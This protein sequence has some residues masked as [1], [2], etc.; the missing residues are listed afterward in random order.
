MKFPRIMACLT[1]GSC[2]FGAGAAFGDQID[3]AMRLLRSVL[4]ANNTVQGEGCNVY[5]IDLGSS[6]EAI[7]RGGTDADGGDRA[8][9]NVGHSAEQAAVTVQESGRSFTLTESTVFR[10]RGGGQEESIFSYDDGTRTI[11]IRNGKSRP[12]IC[13]LK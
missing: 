1:V 8:G 9:F 11:T 12:E 6:T 13:K 5:M 2:L 3:D 4:R 10:G 7:L